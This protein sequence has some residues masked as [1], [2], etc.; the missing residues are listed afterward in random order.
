MEINVQGYSSEPVNFS[1]E[2]TFAAQASTELKVLLRNNLSGRSIYFCQPLGCAARAL[3]S[4]IGVLLAICYDS[5]I[6]VR[7][8][9][10][11]FP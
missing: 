11:I 3:R 6:T 5:K 1:Q 2:E 10:P 9:P 8:V 7:T 4:E